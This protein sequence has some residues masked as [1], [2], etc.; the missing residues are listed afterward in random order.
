MSDDLENKSQQFHQGEY[1][2]RQEHIP[3]LQ[4][5]QIEVFTNVY[6]NSD[7]LISLEF[8][9]FTAICPKTSLPDFGTVFIDYKPKHVCLELKSLKEYFGAYRNLGIFHENVVNKINDDIVAACS[10]RYLKVKAVY[11]ARGGIIT[12]VEKEYHE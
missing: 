3:S 2:G 9:E 1:E 4:L 11:K 10:P 5:P 12:T 6:P 7:Y 8:A